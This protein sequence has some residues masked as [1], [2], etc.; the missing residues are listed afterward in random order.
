MT[1]WHLTFHKYPPIF[2]EP[3]PFVLTPEAEGSLQ[4]HSSGCFS[5]LIWQLPLELATWLC[6]PGAPFM[7]RWYMGKEENMW[8]CLIISAKSMC[9][10]ALLLWFFFFFAL[11][12]LISYSISNI[13]FLNPTLLQ[14]SRVC[15]CCSPLRVKTGEEQKDR[16]TCRSLEETRKMS[17]EEKR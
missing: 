8:V 5:L 10:D 1:T 17:E 7:F 4:N 15:V 9:D 16:Q 12:Y 14:G 3:M 11:F 13:F 6:F 2:F